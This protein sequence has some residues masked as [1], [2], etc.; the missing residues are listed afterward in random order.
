MSVQ[1]LSIRKADDQYHSLFTIPGTDRHKTGIIVVGHCPR[2]STLCL[3]DAIT[4]DQ[5]SQAFPHRISYWKRSNTGG[6]NGLGT[7]YYQHILMYTASLV[8]RPPVSCKQMLT[9]RSK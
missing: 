2:V 5:I 3:P 1:T 6:G 9:A 4:R 7:S 8:Q